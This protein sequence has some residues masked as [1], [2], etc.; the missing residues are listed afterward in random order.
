MGYTPFVCICDPRLNLFKAWNN[1]WPTWMA[2]PKGW[3]FSYINWC[4]STSRIIS[5]RVLWWLMTIKPS[6]GFRP[7]RGWVQH[8]WS[9]ECGGQHG[10][11]SQD[12]SRVHGC[13]APVRSL[14]GVKRSWSWALAWFYAILSS[15][16]SL[17][18]YK[19]TVGWF[20]VVL[21]D[22]DWVVAKLWIVA[23]L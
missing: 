9:D 6:P 12:V 11:W 22:S 7:Q 4:F 15:V 13:S 2:W 8:P 20:E 23:W 14:L 17:L 5:G 1:H 19:G 18:R 21:S 3:P 10:D 16:N